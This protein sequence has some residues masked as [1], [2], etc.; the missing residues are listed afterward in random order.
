MTIR[1]PF[2][3]TVRQFS[4]IIITIEFHSDTD[5]IFLT[6]VRFMYGPEL[7]LDLDPKA[8]RT[9]FFGSLCLGS[10]S[11]RIGTTALY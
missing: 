11:I 2:H 3:G 4:P 1:D 10:K 8:A 9:G 7:N 6:L 5:I